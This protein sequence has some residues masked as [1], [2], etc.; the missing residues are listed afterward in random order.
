MSSLALALLLVVVAV[1]AAP[2]GLPDDAKVSPA[3]VEPMMSPA[4]QPLPLKH[5]RA[6]PS[7][8]EAAAR[9]FITSADAME[10]DG[11]EQ[12][13]RRSA[14]SNVVVNADPWAEIAH[15]QVTP[16]TGRKKKAKR[17]SLALGGA[18]AMAAVVLL[19]AVAWGM[20][21]GEDDADRLS[22]VEQRLDAVSVDF[23][24]LETKIGENNDQINDTIIKELS[25]LQKKV[26]DLEA[27]EGWMKQIFDSLVSSNRN[28]LAVSICHAFNVFIK[29]WE[30]DDTKAIAA[31]RFLYYPDRRSTL[32]RFRLTRTSK[33]DDFTPLLVTN[34]LLL[35][36]DQAIR[37]TLAI[38][39]NKR[40][41]K[42]ACLDEFFALIRSGGIGRPEPYLI[43]QHYRKTAHSN[44]LVIEIVIVLTDARV[45]G[46]ADWISVL[47]NHYVCFLSVEETT[48]FLRHDDDEGTITLHFRPNGGQHPVWWF[49]IHF[50]PQRC[51]PTDDRISS[52]TL[53]AAPV[54]TN[55]VEK[56]LKDL[57]FLSN[58]TPEQRQ[59]ACIVLR[60]LKLHL[61]LRENAESDKM[62][63]MDFDAD[64]TAAA[65]KSITN[66]VAP[67][68]VYRKYMSLKNE[69]LDSQHLFRFACDLA[70]QRDSFT[71]TFD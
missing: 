61:N 51:W 52:P 31:P 47:I 2:V 29:S 1:G 10:E 68:E 42:S 11:R 46:W 15:L 22:V 56:R 49:K 19:S 21:G 53:R 23:C 28:L 50:C 4:A 34:S 71:V 30:K 58:L 39:S 24:D 27:R 25:V 20:A 60:L 35:K 12:R 67:D 48:V 3:V 40:E 5:P 32:G 9:G 37:C 36:L 45:E 43:G 70:P 62:D 14:Q 69:D 64:V 57:R 41:S 6:M 65:S 8:S 54:L 38:E 16:G 63:E 55:V 66:K 18:L 59:S 33:E 13:R 7:P 17:S 26:A 44:D